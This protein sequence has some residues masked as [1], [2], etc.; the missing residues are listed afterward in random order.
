MEPANFFWAARWESST[1][2]NRHTSHPAHPPPDIAISL[3]ADPHQSPHLS[4]TA[5]D[6]LGSRRTRFRSS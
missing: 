4:N 1:H 2:P 3:A 6:A 5:E